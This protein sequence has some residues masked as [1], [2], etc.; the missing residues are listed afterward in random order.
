MARVVD[1]GLRWNTKQDRWD[2]DPSDRA[3]GHH[4]LRFPEAQTH[5]V[6]CPRDN[7]RSLARCDGYGGREPCSRNP[8]PRRDRGGNIRVCGSTRN[9]Q[10]NLRSENDLPDRHSR[11]H[12][13]VGLLDDP[14][15]FGSSVHMGDNHVRADLRW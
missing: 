1:H 7:P 4:D 11:T 9:R 3:R 6:D 15:G 14:S 12:P 13:G 5:N 10:T 2:S 8:V